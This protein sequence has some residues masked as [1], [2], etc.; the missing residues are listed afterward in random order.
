MKQ[1]III[2]SDHAGYETKEYVKKLLHDYDV[3]DVGCF[4]A[5]KKVDY[6]DIAENVGKKVVKQK[7]KGILV[8]GS[9]TGMVIAANKIK[10]IRASLGYDTY[11]A[12]MARLDNDANVLTLRGREFPLQNIKPIVET[13]L[14]TNFS[15][16]PRHQKRIDKI[17]NLEK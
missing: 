2:G 13:W 7:A 9:G 16:E 14:N 8:C 17:K 3:E 5:E 15:K 6:P 1:K 12:K 4:D 10:G 11:S